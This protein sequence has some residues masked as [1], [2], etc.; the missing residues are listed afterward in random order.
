MS[1]RL[2]SETKNI[3][4]FQNFCVE[5]IDYDI[6]SLLDNKD[7]WNIISFY[8]SETCYVGTLITRNTTPLSTHTYGEC[9]CNF[10][11]NCFFQTCINVIWNKKANIINTATNKATELHGTP[12]C[13]YNAHLNIYLYVF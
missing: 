12:L 10:S 1:A 8:T 2:Y 4:K 5:A 7:Y 11:K 13:N 6:E 3:S 9:Q